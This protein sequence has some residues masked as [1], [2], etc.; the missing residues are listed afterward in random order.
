MKAEGWSRLAG[1]ED[2]SFYPMIRKIDVLSSNS[3]LISSDDDLILIDP[4]AIPKQADAILSVIADLP[5]TQNVTGILLTHTHVDHCHSLVSHPRLRSFAD[6]AYSHVSGVKALKTEDYGVTQATLLGKRLSP[7]LLG[8][9]L[10]SGNQESGKYGLPEE[11]ISFPGDLEIIAYHTPGH[12]PE[13]ICYRIGENLFIGDTLF[14]GSPGIA[15][16]VGYS[17]EDLLKSLYGLKKMITGERISVCHSGHGKPIQA[18]DAIRSI[19]LVAKQV[20]ELDG[21][22]THTPGRM[23]ETALFAEDLMAE[24]DET[25]TIIS[26][27]ITYVSH[28]LDELEEGAS[29]GEISTV[30]DSAAV[31]D[32]LARYNSFAEEYRR[33]AHQPI[34]LALNAANIAGKIDRL[35]DRGGLGVVIEPWLIDHLDELINDYMTLF[36]GFRPVATLRDCNPAALCRN[37]VDSLDPRHADQLLESAS[38][39]DFAASLALRMGRV[40]VVNEGS[41][42]V[43]AADE[44]L[45][46]IMDPNRFERA[47]R[48]LITQYAA[49]GADDISIVIHEDYNSIMIRIATADTPPDT[50]QLRYLR[51][52]F[53]LS[54]GT[55]LRSDNRMVVRY[56]AGRTII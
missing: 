25:L 8:N 39:D 7:T 24:I 13:S 2:L 33:G 6:R 1:E 20:R 54:G 50:R 3:F 42:T 37:I 28:M 17:R 21:I 22:E 45:S 14:A 18:Q 19:D 51:K 4:G 12:S 55:V 44:N 23:R 53:A 48:T 9:P 16:M 26:G 29:A 35:I 5:Q 38:A 52:A 56:P 27:R 43:C 15:G 40:Q 36:R 30:L 46:A 47:T 41:V 31:D 49:C 10:F 32:L 34:L 11:T